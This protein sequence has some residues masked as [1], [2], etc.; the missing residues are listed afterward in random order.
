MDKNCKLSNVT[1]AYLNTYYTILNTMIRR[2]SSVPLSCSS[3][4]TFIGQMIPHHE[5]AVRMSNNVLQFNICPELKPILYAIITTN[6][7]A[8]SN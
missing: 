4:E 6:A 8:L 5:G 7:K 3:S 1:Q 2:M